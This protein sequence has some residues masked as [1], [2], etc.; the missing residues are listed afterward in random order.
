MKI[1]KSQL[2]QIIKEELEKVLKESDRHGPSWDVNRYGHKNYSLSLQKEGAPMAA[3]LYLDFPRLKKMGENTPGGV[4][5]SGMEKIIAS[6]LGHDVRTIV[7]D[8]GGAGYRDPS[9]SAYQVIIPW[10][11][12]PK[13]EANLD[14]FMEALYKKV[15]E[16]IETPLRK[17]CEQYAQ[18]YGQIP[19]SYCGTALEDYK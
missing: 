13:L 17:K 6:V 1:T 19:L 18:E 4:D 16:S 5:V 14:S 9:R 15:S 7:D 2:K 8:R 10:P 12:P 3:I 11:A